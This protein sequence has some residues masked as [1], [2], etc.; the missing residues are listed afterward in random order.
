MTQAGYVFTGWNTAANGSGTAYAAGATYPGNTGGA[1]LY[2]QWS[3]NTNTVTYNANG[4]TGSMS[5]QSIATSFSAN[6]TANAFSRTG[7]T[8]AG[9]NTVAGGGGTSYTNG[10]LF[11]M[12]PSSVTLYAQWNANLYTVTYNANGAAGG[13]PAPVSQPFNSSYT[14]S[15]AGSLVQTGYS[16]IGWNTASNGTGTAL[17]AGSIS[18]IGASNLILYAQWAINSYSVTFSANGAS[19]SPPSAAAQN[20]NTVFTVPG[21]GSLVFASMIFD[22][23]NTAADGSGTSYNAGDSLMILGNTTLYAFW[24]STTPATLPLAQTVNVPSGVTDLTS[25]TTNNMFSATGIVTSTWPTT[26]V[27]PSTLTNLGYCAFHDC[28]GLTSITIPSNV[29]SLGYGVFLN[30]TNVTVTMT[31]ATPPSNTVATGA[32]DTAGTTA[33][34]IRVPA[35]YLSTYQTAAGW[36]SYASQMVGY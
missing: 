19:G 1:T 25:G 14:L 15:G 24:L 28:Y 6:L 18:V 17:S 35:A 21:T 2:A 26:V 20:Y 16:F 11:P 27:L 7:Y 9:W 33:L 12:G 30:D 4:G 5:N 3:P 32:F 22:G 8:F 34:V 31:S 23:W 36:S 29:V 13:A 10:Q